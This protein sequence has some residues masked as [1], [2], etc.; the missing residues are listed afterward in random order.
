MPASYL[1]RRP[2]QER[3][4][5]RIDWP[6]NLNSGARFDLD[7]LDRR[8]RGRVTYAEQLV[9]ERAFTNGFPNSGLFDEG[10]RPEVRE[11]F[12][13]QRR[14]CQWGMNYLREPENVLRVGVLRGTHYLEWGGHVDQL[15]I[16]GHLD[17]ALALI[18]EMIDAAHRTEPHED[19]LHGARGLYVK[20]AVILQQMKPPEEADGVVSRV[21]RK[22]PIT[23]RLTEGLPVARKLAALRRAGVLSEADLESLDLRDLSPVGGVNARERDAIGRFVA[24]ESAKQGEAASNPEAKAGGQ[25]EPEA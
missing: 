16:D 14:M 7:W 2:L 3:V 15:S 12:H 21:V 10:V 17:E 8:T 6:V 23:R 18:Y 25:S 9:I 4:L 19:R 5:S 13:R 11:E 24:K 22:Q 20:A 1:T